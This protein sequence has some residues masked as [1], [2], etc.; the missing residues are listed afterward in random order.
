MNLLV[1]AFLSAVKGCKFWQYGV[2]FVAR[3]LLAV[4]PTLRALQC[5]TRS[6]ELKLHHLHNIMKNMMLSFDNYAAITIC[7]VV[8]DY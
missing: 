3:N 1:R 6:V 5:S 8:I 7:S 2:E 4:S